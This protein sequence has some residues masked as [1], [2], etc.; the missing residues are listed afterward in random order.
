MFP[1]SIPPETEEAAFC[2][3]MKKGDFTVWSK[4][5]KFYTAVRSP[6]RKKIALRALACAEDVET[7]FKYVY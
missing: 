5:Y 3:G 1:P 2:E 6:S 7:L 4:M